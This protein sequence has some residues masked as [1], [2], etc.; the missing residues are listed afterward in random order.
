VFGRIRKRSRPQIATPRTRAVLIVN[1]IILWNFIGAA[2]GV[3]IA[4]VVHAYQTVREL[5]R[6]T[7]GPPEW[8]GF[9]GFTNALTRALQSFHRSPHNTSDVYFLQDSIAFVVSLLQPGRRNLF[10]FS[11]QEIKAHHQQ[12]GKRCGAHQQIERGY[13]RCHHSSG[14]HKHHHFHGGAGAME[15]K[16][17]A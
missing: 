13:I 9:A 3:C 7:K 5:R 15:Q 6:F 1:Q 14:N 17:Q 8:R 16:Q 2:V 10:R 12:R 4:L 11:R